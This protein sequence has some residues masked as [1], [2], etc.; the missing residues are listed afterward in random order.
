MSLYTNFSVERYRH[1]RVL[2]LEREKKCVI[3]ET[4]G[5]CRAM[6]LI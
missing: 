6:M 5:L 2:A 1:E 4:T 3:T